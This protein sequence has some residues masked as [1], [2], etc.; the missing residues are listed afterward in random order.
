MTEVK[1][2]GIIR[3]QL[4]CFFVKEKVLGAKR[5][6]FRSKKVETTANH[7]NIKKNYKSMDLLTSSI[8]INQSVSAGELHFQHILYR[9]YAVFLNYMFIIISG[10]NCSVSNNINF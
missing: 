10:F 4:R 1:G 2:I 9:T 6:N 5:E 7:M 8:P 3:P